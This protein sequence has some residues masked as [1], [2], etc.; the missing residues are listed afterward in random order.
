M[1]ILQDNG[2]IN[3]K[4]ILQAVH[5]IS[6][7]QNSDR[8]CEVLLNIM[9]WLLDLDIIERPRDN[10]P[11]TPVTPASDGDHMSETEEKEESPSQTSIGTENDGQGDT[12]AHGLAMDSILK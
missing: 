11:K 7:T 6:N 9:N 10:Q 1:I 5:F 12:T 4:V 2:H 8:I 3:Y